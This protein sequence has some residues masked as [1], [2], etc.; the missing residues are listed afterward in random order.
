M[1]REALSKARA[2]ATQGC[3]RTPSRAILRR[4]NRRTKRSN[5]RR[6]KSTEPLPLEVLAELQRR[7]AAS[8]VRA[9]ERETAVSSTTL[10][11]AL[12][13]EGVTPLVRRYLSLL[14]AQRDAI[15]TPARKAA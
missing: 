3:E 1:M 11:R 4:M 12:R 5:P 10:G 13:G 15:P 7:V 9:V 2:A 14:F 6:P 8:S